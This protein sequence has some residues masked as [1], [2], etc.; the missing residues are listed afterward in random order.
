MYFL[1]DCSS[2]FAHEDIREK[3]LVDGLYLQK[4]IPSCTHFQQPWDQINGT[5]KKNIQRK[6]IMMEQSSSIDNSKSK[7][8]LNEILTNAD[9]INEFMIHLSTEL[10]KH[11]ICTLK[12]QFYIYE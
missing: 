10:C 1:D 6:Q 4:L 7:L 5:F 3:Q 11:N 9:L 8:E 12:F 2:H